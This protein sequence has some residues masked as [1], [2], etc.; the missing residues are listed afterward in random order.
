MVEKEVEECMEY[1]L[2]K[3]II[4]KY[5]RDRKRIYGKNNPEK[6]K[7]S[8]RRYNAK[9]KEKILAKKKKQYKKDPVKFCKRCK[10]WRDNNLYDVHVAD[11]YASI[12]ERCKNRYGLIG[13]TKYHIE[14]YGWVHPPING[15]D[16]WRWDGVTRKN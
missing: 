5:E 3:L 1:M 15:N 7:E 11:M 4:R 16:A 6:K 2:K 8:N 10:A 12:K 14:G 13:K 9:Y